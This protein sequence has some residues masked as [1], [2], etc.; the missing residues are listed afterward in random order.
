[1]KREATHNRRRRKR[2]IIRR[3]IPMAIALVLIAIIL[4]VCLA[5]DFWKKYAYGTEHADLNRYFDI[6]FDDQAAIIM[7]NTILED[8]ALVSDG[9]YYITQEMAEDNFCSNFYFDESE[10]QLLHTGANETIVS[11]ADTKDFIEKDGTVYLAID[12]ISKLVNL[13]VN[14]FENPKR[15]EIKNSWGEVS[16]AKIKKDTE[17]RELGGVKSDILADLKEGETVTVLEEMENW[18]RVKTADCIMGYVENKRLTET[19]TE[20]EE[21][22]T[23]VAEEP[24]LHNLRDYRICL[25]WHQVMS[26]TANATLNDVLAKSRG[27]N[28]ISP[29]WF[30]LADNAGGI[31]NIGTVDYVAKAHDA[32]LEVWALVDNF[33]TGVSTLEVLSK[34]S[35]R[36]IAENNIVNAALE[37][38]V[39]GINI[40][41]ENLSGDCGPAFAQFIREISV[42]CRQHSLVLSVDNYVP[43]GYTAHY[44]RKT[45]GEYADYVVIMGYDEHFSGS[46]E[47]GSVASFNFVQ[48]G[49]ESTL[50]EVAPEQVINGIPFYTRI[51]KE[52][53]EVS[54]EAVDMVTAEE[55]LK[56]HGMTKTWDDVCAQNYA[57]KTEGNTVIKVWLEDAQSIKAKLDLMQANNIA[58][59][60][61][62]K[63][64]M[65]TDD[66]WDVIGEYLGS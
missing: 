2:G 42:L 48:D 16:R 10:Q 19:Y 37:L 25:G 35:V 65:E 44:D 33:D 36:K 31:K 8:K 49:I 61:C 32:G 13:E 14:S 39:D 5:S 9:R 57:E 22:V 52:G 59:V 45:Q 51:W 46:E 62:W 12:Y 29:T 20:S 43:K 26:A 58:G 17:V 4:L 34:T 27:I 1:M 6:F 40:D 7:D 30:S 28:V 56:N 15:I 47:S 23:S 3:L 50:A 38:G 18:T 11:T 64:G 60:A 54:S 63:L 41:F 21:P 53:A 24:I 66:I 55:F